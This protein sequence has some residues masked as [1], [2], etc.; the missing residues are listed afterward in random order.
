[1]ATPKGSRTMVIVIL[2]VLVIV[3]AAFAYYYIQASGTI[4]SQ[5]GQIATANALIASDN[6]K[7][8]NLSSTISSLQSQVAADQAKIDSLTAK[9]T[10]ANQTIASL[11]TQIS[12]LNSQIATLQAQVTG[13][14]AQVASLQGII[15]L[16]QTTQELASTPFTF[17]GQA[18]AITFTAAYAGYV[19]VSVSAASDYPN[20]GAQATIVF[21]S[22]IHSPVY[23]SITIPFSGF[24]YPFSKVPDTLIFPVVPGTVTVTLVTSDPT[25]QT[26]TLAVVYYY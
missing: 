13:L 1:M 14:Q 10:Q 18:T 16:T 4:S 25:S 26:A 5:A 19:L 6:T 2:V 24:F 15:G 22:S 8:A 23:S 17:S 21:A 11:N 20:E 9:Y 3:G 12:T 7:I